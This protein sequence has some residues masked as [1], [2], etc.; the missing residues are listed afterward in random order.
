[1]TSD[2]IFD[3]YAGKTMFYA[4]FEYFTLRIYMKV[5]KNYDA[6]SYTIFVNFRVPITSKNVRFGKN[7]DLTIY[8]FP[9][10]E[11]KTKLQ[12]N[13][14]WSMQIHRLGPHNCVSFRHA[15]GGSVKWN[16]KH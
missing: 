8:I 4:Y 6:E 5:S 1:M 16:A 9:Q 13:Q 2:V 10:K 3:L 11:S 12:A 14:E 15:N 7:D